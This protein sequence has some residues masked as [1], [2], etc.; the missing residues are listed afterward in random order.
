[1]LRAAAIAALCALIA[2]GASAQEE[3]TSL[4]EEDVVR[5]FAA[6]RGTAAILEEIARRP[7]RFVL[8]GEILEE[9][10][11]AGLPPEILAAMRAKKAEA[12]RAERP[13]PPPAIV[14]ETRVPLTLLLN[15]GRRPGKPERLPLAPK[16]GSELGRSL[17]L[18]PALVGSDFEDVAL[19]LACLSPTHVPDHWRS[20]SPLGRDFARTPRHEVLSFLAG[21]VRVE[22]DL[23]LEIPP[24]LEALLD[25]GAAHDLLLGVAAQIGGRFYL[26]DY[27]VWEGVLPRPSPGLTATISK[28]RPGSLAE[29]DVRCE[30][31]QLE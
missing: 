2:L 27:D 12:D 21:A 1:M 15:P 6:G 3:Q 31:L 18:E 7:Q 22:Q 13:A 5:M 25:P 17:E 4:T 30:S 10:R 28:G 8:D 9:L 14:E 24:S 29:I 11:A 26:L 19:V 16:V 20:A 23:W